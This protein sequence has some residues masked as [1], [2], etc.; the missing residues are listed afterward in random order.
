[1]KTILLFIP[2]IL[3][4]CSTDKLETFVDDV[5]DTVANKV[6]HSDKTLIVDRIRE[7]PDGYDIVWKRAV[8]HFVSFDTAETLIDQNSGLLKGTTNKL[9]KR[10]ANCEDP[11]NFSSGGG[12]VYIVDRQATLIITIRSKGSRT[13]VN[14]EPSFQATAIVNDAGKESILCTSTGKFERDAL[15][16]IAK[17]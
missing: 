5:S 15:D 14:V 2:L 6:G 13:E 17:S 1:M 7:S 4:A 12:S 11:S 16:K 10:Y 9:G 3:S 8:A